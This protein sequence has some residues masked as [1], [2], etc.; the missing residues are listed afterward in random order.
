MS[1]RVF[2][3]RANLIAPRVGLTAVKVVPAAAEVDLVKA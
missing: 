3:S 1:I 2:V